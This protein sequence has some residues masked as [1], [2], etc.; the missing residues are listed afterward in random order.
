MKL[1]GDIVGGSAIVVLLVGVVLCMINT[2]WFPWVN[3]VGLLIAL[4]AIVFLKKRPA[5]ETPGF[6][7]TSKGGMV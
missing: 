1:K 2:S 5:Q 7:R 4:G 3:L 6:Q